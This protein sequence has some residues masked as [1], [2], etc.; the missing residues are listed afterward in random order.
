[1]DAP[2]DRIPMFVKAGAII[3]TQ[4]VVQYTDQAP[5]D[6]LT[7]TAYPAKTGS[8]LYYEDDGHTFEYEQGA[9]FK[10]TIVQTTSERST[11]LVIGK[12][13]GSYTPPDRSIIVQFVDMG[14]EPRE[15]LIGGKKISKV[16]ASKLRSLKVGWSYD[17]EKKVVMVKT[18]EQPS[19]IVVEVQR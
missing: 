1:M 4:Q 15:V 17:G 8:A 16:E 2:I 18:S 19:E 10:R 12:A 9:F 7:L 14:A 13:A 6:P 11:E 3:P 5:I